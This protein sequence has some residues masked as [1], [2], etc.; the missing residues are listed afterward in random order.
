MWQKARRTRYVDQSAFGLA[1]VLSIRPRKE[2]H[3]YGE[4]IEGW[5]LYWRTNG[6]TCSAGHIQLTAMLSG[7]SHVNGIDQPL[8][9]ICRQT[10]QSTMI[11]SA[12][13]V[14]AS[15]RKTRGGPISG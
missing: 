10:S 8:D 6:R 1:R 9:V 11:N 5:P 12:V 14:L 13:E 4:P 7:R 3:A 2:G 15:G